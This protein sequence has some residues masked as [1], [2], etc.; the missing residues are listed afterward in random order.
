MTRTIPLIVTTGTPLNFP[1]KEI[2]PPDRTNGMR[3]AD[4]GWRMAD[5]GWRMA[6]TRNPEPGTR[7]PTP[8]T[9]NPKPG[10]RTG[11]P[12]AHP[13]R[14]G[15]S[16][17]PHG[18]APAT[19]L[20]TRRVFTLTLPKKCARRQGNR[21]GPSEAM[22]GQASSLLSRVGQASSLPSGREA[23]KS[24][25]RLRPSGRQD[26][27]PTVSGYM[28]LPWAQPRCREVAVDIGLIYTPRIEVRLCGRSTCS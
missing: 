1:P 20:G 26:A 16:T 4:G 11:T 2:S 8:E 6:T 9:R 15:P 22:V 3:M 12:F 7:N 17:P 23:R 21:I 13:S 25:L 18:S 10:T 14:A 27:C 28:R 24:N 5:G 19:K